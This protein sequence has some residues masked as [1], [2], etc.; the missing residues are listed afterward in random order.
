MISKRTGSGVDDL[1]GVERSWPL[2]SAKRAPRR[3]KKHHNTV[4]NRA[5]QERVR[6]KHDGGGKDSRDLRHETPWD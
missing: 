1:Q 6:K 5:A 3:R 2:V 4:G